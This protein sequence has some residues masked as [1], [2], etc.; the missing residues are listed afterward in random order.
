MG[1]CSCES[2]CQGGVV[3]ECS[4]ESMGVCV[5]G[6]GGEVGDCMGVCVSGWGGEVAECECEYMGGGCWG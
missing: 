2:M 4:C 1:E 5:S 3:G 6:W